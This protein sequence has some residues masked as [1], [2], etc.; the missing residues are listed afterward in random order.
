MA[1]IHLCNHRHQI[2]PANQLEMIEIS[3]VHLCNHSPGGAPA[4]AVP[5]M[6]KRLVSFHFIRV[7]LPVVFPVARVVFEP[8]PVAK[9]LLSPVVRIGPH[10]KSLPCR[11]SGTLAVR[12][13][14]IVLRA[15]SWNEK[16]AAMNTRDRF[17]MPSP[18][19]R[20]NKS[21]YMDF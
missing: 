19:N 10:L 7:A 2:K 14:T 13:R 11:L 4:T 20:M 16:R 8:F 17:H 12:S 9:F 21:N 3:R 1:H 15:V 5:D 18:F 6:L